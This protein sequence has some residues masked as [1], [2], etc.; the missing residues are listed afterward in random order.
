MWQYTPAILALGRWRQEEKRVKAM[1]IYLANCRPTEA[2]RNSVFIIIRVMMMTQWEN[3]S[4][5]DQKH[6]QYLSQGGRMQVWVAGGLLLLL[7]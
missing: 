5:V 1:F 6:S 2:V 3:C 4:R 7:G